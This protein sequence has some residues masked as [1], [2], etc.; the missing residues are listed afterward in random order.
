MFRQGWQRTPADNVNRSWGYPFLYETYLYHIHRLDHRHNFSPYFYAIYLSLF[1]PSE[2]QDSWTRSVSKIA[3]HPL[4]SFLP[5]MTLALGSGLLLTNETSLEFAMFVQTWV[6]VML[7]KVCTSQVSIC[8][9]AFQSWVV[10]PSRLLTAYMR[11][12]LCGGS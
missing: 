9:L 5:Q 1:S 4:A 7:N 11:S 10:A 2:Q 3:Q 6:F 12:I 8:A